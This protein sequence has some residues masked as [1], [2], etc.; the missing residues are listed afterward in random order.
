MILSSRAWGTF[1]LLQR[2]G[3]DRVP[4]PHVP[5]PEYRTP[6][7]TPWL[8]CMRT[9]QFARNFSFFGAGEGI[10]AWDLR[11]NNTGLLHLPP[12]RWAEAGLSHLHSPSAEPQGG[13]STVPQIFHQPPPRTRL[14]AL[15]SVQVTLPSSFELGTP[16][17]HVVLV[18]G[19]VLK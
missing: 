8:V 10:G 4:L 1:P 15:P 17:R 16:S 6:A 18:L 2:A 12:L 19:V 9:S 13:H 11:R 7:A 5:L 14:G 3:K